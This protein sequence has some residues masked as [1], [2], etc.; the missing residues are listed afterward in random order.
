MSRSRSPS[1]LTETETVS[2]PGESEELEEL[3]RN[4]AKCYPVLEEPSAVEEEKEKGGEEG[5]DGK[6]VR[7]CESQQE[8]GGNDGGHK[9]EE[10]G[11]RGSGEK[12]VNKKELMK[13]QGFVNYTE[14]EFFDRLV[15]CVMH[16]L[17]VV[18]SF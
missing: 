11:D 5:R 8:E 2:T 7:G 6:V 15:L 3:K 18:V 1:P 16:A 9:K 12:V 14:G 4:Y 17:F 13:C 10:G